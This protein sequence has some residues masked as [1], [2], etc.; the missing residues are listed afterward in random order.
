MGARSHGRAQL[1]P[2]LPPAQGSPGCRQPVP[3]GL[4]PRGQGSLE[5]ERRWK[6]YLE[7]ERIALFLQNEEFMKELQRNRD[8]LL[9]LERGE[10]H[11]GKPL[12]AFRRT[13]VL[14]GGPGCWRGRDVQ[15][16]VRAVV[17]AQPANT[18]QQGAVPLL[19]LVLSCPPRGSSCPA[20]LWQGALAVPSKPIPG[21]QPAWF[22]Q[23]CSSP[24]PTHLP[25]SPH[26]LVL[27]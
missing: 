2:R 20:N 18:E 3:R 13:E 22:Y 6:Q 24:V 14:L 10:E 27:P 17:A 19:L 21:R 5:Q 4:V 23:G 25:S 8:F 7:D 11:R 15:D 16:V 12:P 26:V 1:L 9:A